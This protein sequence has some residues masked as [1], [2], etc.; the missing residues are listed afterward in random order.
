MIEIAGVSESNHCKNFD[1]GDIVWLNSL[2]KD[3]CILA[4]SSF[5]VLFP[6]AASR[7]GAHP[8]W[9]LLSGYVDLLLRSE[10]QPLR[11]LITRLGCFTI[12]RRRGTMTPERR[13]YNKGI[14]EGTL[15]IV[16]TVMG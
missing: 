2:L 6:W 9:N 7:Q 11:K 1:S 4:S 15:S 16:V 14:R 5:F 3:I 13:G 10:Q 8:E 12:R